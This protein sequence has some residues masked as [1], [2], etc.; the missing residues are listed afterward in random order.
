MTSGFTIIETMIVLA[1]TGFILLGAILAVQGKTNET[2]YIQVVNNLQS[3]L[4]RTVSNVINGYSQIFASNTE[5]S[6]SQ[7]DFTCTANPATGRSNGYLSF[8][9]SPSQQGANEGCTF[10]GYVLQFTSPNYSSSAEN[11]YNLYT[12]AGIQYCASNVLTSGSSCMTPNVIPITLQEEAPTTLYPASSDSYTKSLPT[13]LLQQESIQ[14]GVHAVAMYYNNNTRNKIGAF[15]ILLSP[16]ATT[17]QVNLYAIKNSSFSIN[18]TNMASIINRSLEDN[19]IAVDSV[20]ICLAS[21]S[22]NQSGLITIGGSSGQQTT[23]SLRIYTGT[24][25]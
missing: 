12:I 6:N 20:E 5:T 13:S 10:L 3:Q 22:S 4:Q 23:V 24:T 15:A 25:C 9:S 21:G 16:D 14:F 18:A 8:T 11:F 2:E 19:P 17:Q 1:V 7:Y